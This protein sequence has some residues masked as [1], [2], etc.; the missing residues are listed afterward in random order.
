MAGFIAPLASLGG[1]RNQGVISAHLETITSQTIKLAVAIRKT[2][3]P[4][5]TDCFL[6]TL[7]IQ[8]HVEALAYQSAQRA[9][10]GV[11]R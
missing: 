7:I 9:S 1:S 11:V 10:I 3:M 4:F 2:H 6:L 5:V 8:A